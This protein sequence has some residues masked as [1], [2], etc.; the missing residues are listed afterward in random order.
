M[1]NMITVTITV[2]KDNSFNTQE[3]TFYLEDEHDFKEIYDCEA[4]RELVE[5]VSK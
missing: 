4:V 3:K 1:A 2:D 5:I